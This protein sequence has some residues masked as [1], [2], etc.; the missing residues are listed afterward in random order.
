VF[1]LER[2]RNV[3]ICMSI[4]WDWTYISNGDTRQKM[5]QIC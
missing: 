4:L 1:A 5:E 2:L 3:F